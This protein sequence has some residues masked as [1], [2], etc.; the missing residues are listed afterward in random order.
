[1]ATRTV[2]PLNTVFAAAHYA[3]RTNGGYFKFPTPEVA[4]INRELMLRA[5]RGE[6]HTPDAAD[7]AAAHEMLRHFRTIAFRILG[8]DR[9][10]PFEHTVAALIERTEISSN[11]DLAICASLPSV[12][13][14]G[15]QR[16][17]VDDRIKW[18]RGGAVGAVGDRPTLT[19][20]VLQSVWSQQWV[21]HYVTA[22]TADDQ[23]VR[24]STSKSYTVGSTVTVRGTVRSVDGTVTRLGRVSPVYTPVNQPVDDA[25]HSPSPNSESEQ[26]T[27]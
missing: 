21:C 3:H 6:G 13:E 8:G 15:R 22:I 24:W 27:A 20:T 17:S 2:Y 16:R 11:Y 9:V 4:V 18:A 10:S 7:E 23:P 12:W 14:R 19:V 1:M 5:L 25:A 26:L